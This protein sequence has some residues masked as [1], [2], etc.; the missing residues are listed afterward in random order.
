MKARASISLD[1]SLLELA[2]RRPQ[3]LSKQVASALRA[4][5]DAPIPGKLEL[6]IDPRE[7]RRLHNRA[8]ALGREPGELLEALIREYAD[9]LTDEDLDPELRR[10][11]ARERAREILG[12]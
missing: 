7:H 9:K 1:P 10:R 6:E 3:P 4:E 11:R 8:A 12:G 5:L 2:R